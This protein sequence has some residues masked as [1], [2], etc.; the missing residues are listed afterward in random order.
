M[1]LKVVGENCSQSDQTGKYS[2]YHFKIRFS[3]INS[4]VRSAQTFARR[5]GN[6]ANPGCPPTKLGANCVFQTARCTEPKLCALWPTH[7]NI[8]NKKYCSACK[9]PPA[10]TYC[11]KVT[12]LDISNMSIWTYSLSDRWGRRLDTPI[13]QHFPRH[14]QG[15]P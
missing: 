1:C 2:S 4:L 3:N 9:T 7:P 8:S 15:G 6:L 5:R 13:S 10:W 14:Q 12:Y 11:K